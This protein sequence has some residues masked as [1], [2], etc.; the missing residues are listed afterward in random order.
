VHGAD[1][2]KNSRQA[3]ILEIIEKNDVETQEELSRRLIE[4]GYDVTQATV[5]RDIKNLR[6]VK[7]LGENGRHKYV[8]NSAPDTKTGDRFNLIFTQSVNHVDFA[9]NF[10]VL[11]TLPGAA[12][13]TAMA[14]DSLKN[15]EIMGTLAGDDTVFILMRTPESAEKF[16]NYIKTMIE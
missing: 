2:M 14:L 5:S 7:V 8:Q 13:V 15:D 6:I 12:Q 9:V 3:K 10:I 4:A 1:G 11:K 16:Y